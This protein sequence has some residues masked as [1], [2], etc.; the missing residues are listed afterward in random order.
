MSSGAH[1]SLAL[2]SFKNAHG[3][4]KALKKEIIVQNWKTN[5]AKFMQENVL[6]PIKMLLYQFV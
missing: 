4:N 5:I 3:R 1:A 2:T 6:N